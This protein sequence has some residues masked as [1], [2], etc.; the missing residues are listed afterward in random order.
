[1]V[2][3]DSELLAGSLGEDPPQLCEYERLKKRNIRERDEAL[4]EAMGEIEED[5]QDMRDNAPRVKGAS[6]ELSFGRRKGGG[7]C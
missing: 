4:K 3:R 1:M 6:E 7:E 2:I 5:K